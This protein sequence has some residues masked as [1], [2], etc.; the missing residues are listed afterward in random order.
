MAAQ[1]TTSRT[2]PGAPAAAGSVTLAGSPSGMAGCI[3]S[4]P[5]TSQSTPK[6]TRISRRAAG[7]AASAAAAGP[8]RCRAA[9]SHSRT[10]T[11]SMAS[12]KKISRAMIP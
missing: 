2:Q 5:S 6:P 7:S 4:T 9:G 8:D 11:H 3:C 12:R 1:S 10:L